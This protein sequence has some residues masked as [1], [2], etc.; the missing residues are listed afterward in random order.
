MV[1]LSVVVVVLLL[2]VHIFLCKMSSN[3]FCFLCFIFLLGVQVCRFFTASLSIE[4]LTFLADAYV[5]V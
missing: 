3:L 4:F 5:T 1:R 2:L